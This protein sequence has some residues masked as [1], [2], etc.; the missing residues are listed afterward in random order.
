MGRTPISHVVYGAQDVEVTAARLRR[1]LGLRAIPGSHFD[2]LGLADWFVPFEDQ[3]IELLTV[4]D[5][6]VAMRTPFGRWVAERTATGDRLLAWALEAEG[7]IDAVGR[8]LGAEPDALS[9]IDRTGVVRVSQLAG[10][11][12]AFAEPCFPF[13]VAWEEPADLRRALA[14]AS[15]SVQ[16]ESGARGIGWV[17][18]AGEESAMHEWLAGADADVRI[19]AGEPDLLAIGLRTDNDDVVVRTEA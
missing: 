9:F 18:V 6:E 16:H 5:E 10:A 8:R 17:E 3:Y 7:D 15:A 1:G 14:E 12:R 11:G 2:E 19:T 13:F 4:A